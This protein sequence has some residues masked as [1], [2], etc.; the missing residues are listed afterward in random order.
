MLKLLQIYLYGIQGRPDFPQVKMG[1]EFASKE[2]GWMG[3]K[4][5]GKFLEGLSSQ[6]GMVVNFHINFVD[7]GGL[8]QESHQGQIKYISCMEGCFLFL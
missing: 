6:G 7:R 1:K 3:N 4:E 8:D 5:F 2:M